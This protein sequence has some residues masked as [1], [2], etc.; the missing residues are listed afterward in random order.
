MEGGS[1]CRAFG[2]W[3]G[4]LGTSESLHVSTQPSVDSRSGQPGPKM[5]IWEQ[6]ERGC[7][8]CTWPA[9]VVKRQPFRAG[10]DRSRVTRD[11]EACAP[12]GRG[13]AWPQ[14]GPSTAREGAA[15]WERRR[16]RGKTALVFEAEGLKGGCVSTLAA[17]RVE[18]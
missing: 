16:P 9:L 13:L 7:P 17:W 3:E 4:L 11:R 12:G 1:A 15:C 14:C 2:G 8:E 18:M 6:W 10:L 5:S